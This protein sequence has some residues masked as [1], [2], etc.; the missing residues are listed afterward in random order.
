MDTKLFSTFQKLNCGMRVTQRLVVE[1]ITLNLAT[2]LAMITDLKRYSIRRKS[3]SDAFW[4][5]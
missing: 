1:N 2:I 3:K 4:E 5:Y